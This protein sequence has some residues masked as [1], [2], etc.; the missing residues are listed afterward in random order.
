MSNDIIENSNEIE[1]K[2]IIE[3]NE[4]LKILNDMKKCVVEYEKLYDEMQNKIIENE[5]VRA[6]VEENISEKYDKLGR[7]I[8]CFIGFIVGDIIGVFR[9]DNEA[10]SGGIE[11][12]KEL[13]ESPS[14]FA[15]RY[16]YDNGFTKLFHNSEYS[17][18]ALAVLLSIVGYFVGHKLY[19]FI[20][21]FVDEKKSSK[22]SYLENYMKGYNL[23][24][25]ELQNTLNNFWNIPENNRFKNIIP[26]EY[27]KI[28]VVEKIIYIIEIGKA[29]NINDALKIL[30]NIGN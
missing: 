3:K 12:F 17:T 26:M 29:N 16:L 30:E 6:E 9:G 27:M 14:D 11:L 5:R 21:C 28:N 15:D 24:K 1:H 23:Q 22:S 7:N 4:N 8:F 25:Q 19:Q 18:F 13:F 2:R 20:M 10:I